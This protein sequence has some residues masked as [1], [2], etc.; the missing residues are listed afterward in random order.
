MPSTHKQN[1]KHVDKAKAVLDEYKESAGCV[2]CGFNLWPEALQFDHENQADKRDK[3]G[4]VR[5]R[6]KLTSGAKL[7]RYLDHVSKYCS[8]RCANCH[9]HRTKVEKQWQWRPEDR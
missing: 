9:A 7:H 2:D 3:P 4:W 1:Q 8:V 6:S 5:D